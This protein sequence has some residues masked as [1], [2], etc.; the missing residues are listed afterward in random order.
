MY[1]QEHFSWESHLAWLENIAEN[2]CRKDWVVSLDKQPV[3]RAYLTERN[4]EKGECAFGMFISSQRA[5][6]IGAGAAA[7]LL[8]LD[9]AFH[10]WHLTSVYCEVF[11]S[12]QPPLRMHH[13]MGFTQE[14]KLHNH[15]LFEG[16][17]IDIIVLRLLAT[18]WHTQR[19]S[20]YK[21]L[22]KILP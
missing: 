14:K 8:A 22:K 18:T 5:R 17:P 11:A 12:N 21:L 6:L 20:I 9:Y 19:P 4:E 1:E 15:A 3:G 10:Q 7:E 16:K 2:P 13:R